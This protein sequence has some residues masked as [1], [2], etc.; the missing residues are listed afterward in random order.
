MN[1]DDFDLPIPEECR[2]CKLAYKGYICP[3]RLYRKVERCPCPECIV[4]V[5]CFIACRNFNIGRSFAYNTPR[6]YKKATW[7]RADEENS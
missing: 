6:K 7:E 4:K 2:G 5:S 1:F 3:F